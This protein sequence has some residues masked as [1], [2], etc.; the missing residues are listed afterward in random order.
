MFINIENVSFSLFSLKNLFI[1]IFNVEYIF[2]IV[3]VIE[4]R[5]IFKCNEK[6]EV[7]D[8]IISKKVLFVF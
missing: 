8:G 1:G 2:I 3:F 7:I 4:C 5:D 6:N